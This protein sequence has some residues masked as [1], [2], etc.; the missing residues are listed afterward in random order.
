MLR[1]LLLAMQDSFLRVF[2]AFE[3]F[4]VCFRMPPLEFGLDL[5]LWVAFGGLLC[6]TCLSGTLARV[7]STAR[8][9]RSRKGP[10]R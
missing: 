4:V 8:V 6:G 3:P 9:P 10:P 2:G 1:Y 7:W 5:A